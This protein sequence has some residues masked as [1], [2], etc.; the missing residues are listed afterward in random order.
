MA[1]RGAGGGQ[2]LGEDD[3]QQRDEAHL[4]Q[5]VAVEDAGVADGP[6]ALQVGG[7]RLVGVVV[8]AQPQ[9]VVGPGQIGPQQAQ[10]QPR[11]PGQHSNNDGDEQGVGGQQRPPGRVRPAAE[12]GLDG[13]GYVALGDVDP[14]L[15][16]QLDDDPDA[17]GGRDDGHAAEVARVPPQSRRLEPDEEVLEGVGKE[18]QQRP[19]AGQLEQH[20][21]DQPVVEQEA[22]DAEGEQVRP[23]AK[24]ADVGHGQIVDVQRLVIALVAVERQVGE[25]LEDRLVYAVE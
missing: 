8:G 10:Q 5:Q 13:V 20:D 21:A 3:H 23:V 7:R 17:D 2:H 1:D 16:R 4:L 6:A 12:Q 11:Q 22:A 19:Q 24:G 18:D 14:V 15:L 9:L 25:G